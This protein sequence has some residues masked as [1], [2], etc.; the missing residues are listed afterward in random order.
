MCPKHSDYQSVRANTPLSRPPSP[1]S[2]S[3]L[4]TQALLDLSLAVEEDLQDTS[5]V[6]T[7]PLKQ[8]VQ[9][10][11]P[12]P[13]ESKDRRSVDTIFALRWYYNHGPNRRS[14]GAFL[15]ELPA[16]SPLEQHVSY[17]LLIPPPQPLEASLSPPTPP[18]EQHI[19]ISAA[20]EPQIAE[21]PGSVPPTA[22]LCAPKSPASDLPERQPSG[23]TS[24]SD[25]QSPRHMGSPRT[26]PKVEGVAKFEEIQGQEEQHQS[27]S[28]PQH[29][30]Q[31][32]TQGKAN[33]T[34]AL[35]PDKAAGASFSAAATFTTLN[36]KQPLA[37]I[38]VVPSTSR[39]SSQTRP[40]SS[41]QSNQVGANT[42]KA[43]R[44]LPPVILSPYPMSAPLPTIIPLASPNQTTTAPGPEPSPRHDIS[45]DLSS[46]LVVVSLGL[47]LGLDLGQVTSALA[48]STVPS[49]APAT[50]SQFPLNPCPNLTSSNPPRTPQSTPG[51]NPNF[52][53]LTPSAA[54]AAGIN[55]NFAPPPKISAGPSG[56]G[57]E[58]GGLVEWT[59]RRYGSFPGK[60]W[61][62]G[63]GGRRSLTLLSFGG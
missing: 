49:S 29:K 35:P 1:S 43:A 31:T 16:T 45:L 26:S 22:V 23:Q 36:R 3:S 56:T 6:Q 52:A 30:E 61:G 34:Q 19:S 51:P 5:L 18:P 38:K 25:L 9:T 63:S 39:S 41:T 60:W 46:G 59:R 24:L 32:Q 44:T 50:R 37:P 33:K 21:L 48:P 54:A 17:P 7:Q 14:Q 53:P 62:T 55:L 20:F 57:L 15:P 47:G 58:R 42:T 4:D 10:Q 40:S 28:T 13:K 12:V 11:S 8:V 27:Q 2:L